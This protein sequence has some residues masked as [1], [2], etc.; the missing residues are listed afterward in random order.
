MLRLN[1]HHKQL[2]FFDDPIFVEG[3]LDAQ[4]VGALQEARGISVAGAGSCVIDAGGCEE[5]NRYLELCRAFSKN[6]YFLYDLDSLF[7]GNLRAC[8][9]ADGSVQHFLATA[10]MGN[11]FG[12]YRGELERRLTNVIDQLHGASPVPPAL[13]RLV[14]YLS[15]LGP[16]DPWSS[17]TWVKARVSVLTAI[18]RDHAAVDKAPFHDDVKDIEGRLNQIAA[19]LKQVNVFLLP[20]GTLERYLPEYS[21]DPYEPTDEAKRQAVYREIEEL[22]KGM[23]AEQLAARYKGLYDAVC[24]MPGKV[25]VDVERVLRDYLSQYIHDLQVAVSSHPSWDLPQVQEYLGTVQRSTVKLFSVQSLQRG[26]GKKE[27]T[28]VVRIAEIGGER[29]KLVRV[30]HRTNAGMGEFTIE[31]A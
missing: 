13:N 5:V 22:G 11:D 30:D 25:S 6:A 2:S 3:I 18:S 15:R 12:R 16:R 28:A 17:K 31:S 26:E 29:P 7:E 19:A 14:D 23:T 1:V 27:F 21:G 9:K 20:G 24:A 8:V 4:L 10:G